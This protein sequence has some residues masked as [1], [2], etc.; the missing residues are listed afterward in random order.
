MTNNDFK[1]L[2]KINNCERRKNIIQVKD[3]WQ[4]KKK[5]TL[6][7]NNGLISLICKVHLENNTNNPIEKWPKNMKYEQLLHIYTFIIIHLFS[8][9]MIVLVV[10]MTDIKINLTKTL[11]SIILL[12]NTN[13]ATILQDQAMGNTSPFL[14]WGWGA[15]WYHPLRDH[16]SS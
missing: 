15:M 9:K 3:K 11:R 10:E 16:I 14:S 8:F 5:K 12:K 2:A 6:L 13:K 1:C 4:I 7:T